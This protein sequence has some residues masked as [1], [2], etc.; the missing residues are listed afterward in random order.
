MNRNVIPFPQ[1]K[2]VTI[3]RVSKVPS[4]VRKLAASLMWTMQI[5]EGLA[6]VFIIGEGDEY[7]NKRAIE[8]WLM[9]HYTEEEVSSMESPLSSLGSSLANHITE[10]HYNK[11]ALPC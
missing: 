8:T 7:S 6:L 4:Y 1:Q 5:H 2:K 9:T 10:H 3:A 11:E